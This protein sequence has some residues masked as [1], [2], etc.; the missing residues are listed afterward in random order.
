VVGVAE[1]VVARRILVMIRER[2]R[3]DDLAD[4]VVRPGP[5]LGDRIIVDSE[6]AFALHLYALDAD[7]AH[8]RVAQ[9]Q[10]IEAVPADDLAH[11]LAHFDVARPL[12]FQRGSA[13]TLV[14]RI[15][16]VDLDRVHLA[17]A[18]QAEQRLQE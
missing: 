17:E 8:Q 5:A 15:D 4:R 6:E 10:G 7:G 2:D 9:R 1:V 16:D 14:L 11:P 3:G 18:L 13:G 12:L